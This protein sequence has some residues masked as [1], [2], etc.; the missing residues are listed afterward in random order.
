MKTSSL[1][2]RIFGITG[3]PMLS[4]DQRHILAGFFANGA[5]LFLGLTLSDQPI[6]A[7]PMTGGMRVVMMGLSAAFLGVGLLVEHAWQRRKHD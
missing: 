1:T 6:V 3:I 2:L 7:H 5:V 4:R